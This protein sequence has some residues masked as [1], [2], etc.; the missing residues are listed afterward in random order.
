MSSSCHLICD[1]SCSGCQMPQSSLTSSRSKLKQWRKSGNL[2]VTMSW[3]TWKLLTEGG[4]TVQISKRA[5]TEMKA[6][7][8]PL[9]VLADC[10]L[11]SPRGSGF[12]SRHGHLFR[13]SCTAGWC[14]NA[15]LPAVCVSSHQGKSKYN[16]KACLI[17]L[18]LN[19]ASKQLSGSI[20][21]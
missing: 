7:A 16:N 9:I 11:E 18:Y 20:K 19:S 12:D 5:S 8:R 17:L 2:K 10:F 21:T 13:G 3:K 14:H 1:P 4:F 15:H 6:A